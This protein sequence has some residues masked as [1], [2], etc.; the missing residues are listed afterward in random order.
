VR[1]PKHCFRRK[2]KPQVYSTPTTHLLIYHNFQVS[3]QFGAFHTARRFF[4]SR[5]A[6]ARTSSSPITSHHANQPLT[7]TQYYASGAF[8]GLANSILSGPIEHIRI[9]LQTQPHVPHPS[10][11][12]YTGPIS[13]TRTLIAQAGVGK[14]LYRGQAVTL[15]REAQAYGV[16]FAT[17]EFLMQGD[18][19]RRG[20]RGREEVEPWRLALYGG[21]AGEMLWLASYPFDVVKS[22]MQ[23]DGLVVQGAGRKTETI[24]QAANR[25]FGEGAVGVREADVK[26]AAEVKFGVQKYGSMRDCFSQTWR[27]E[28]MRGFWKGIGPTLLRAMPVSAATFFV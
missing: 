11:R 5:N 19:A 6:A 23:S 12:L 27:Q 21:L 26:D 10:Q 8:A 25:A 20:L 1:K 4:Q 15:L 16:W 17:Y 24:A 22:K 13:C 7:Y 9:R 3:I 28:G 18:V 14:G 2:E